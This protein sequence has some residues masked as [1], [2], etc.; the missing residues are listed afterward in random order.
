MQVLEAPNPFPNLLQLKS[1]TSFSDQFKDLFL[2][3]NFPKHMHT[4]AQLE[5]SPSSADLPPHMLVSIVLWHLSHSTMETDYLCP[6]LHPH[7][8]L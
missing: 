1:S 3:E 4:P 8:G 7:T 2:H 6:C 5:V